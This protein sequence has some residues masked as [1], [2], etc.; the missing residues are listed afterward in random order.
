M[1]LLTQPQHGDPDTGPDPSTSTQST[2]SGTRVGWVTQELM[3]LEII[4]EKRPCLETLYDIFIRTSGICHRQNIGQSGA[5]MLNNSLREMEPPIYIGV[6]CWPES[7]KKKV[8]GGF[9]KTG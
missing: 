3:D 6:Q 9:Q 2:S 4:T 1:A 5:R 8:L 7:D